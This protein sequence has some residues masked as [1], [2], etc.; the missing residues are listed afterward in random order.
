MAQLTTAQ[1]AR[2]SNPTVKAGKLAY[3][4]FERPDIEKAERFLTDFGLDMAQRS[5]DALYLRAADAAPFC[6]TVIR[7]DQ[8]RFVGFGLA[9]TVLLSQRRASSRVNKMFASL[10]AE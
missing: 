7:G 6:Y 1:P 10:L 2:H 8:A 5:A 4:I 9:V 3:L